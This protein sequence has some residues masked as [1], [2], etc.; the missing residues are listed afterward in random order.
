MV[1][2]TKP[3]ASA[4]DF[5]HRRAE[6]IIPM[7]WLLTAGLA[8]PLLLKPALSERPIGLTTILSSFAFLPSYLGPNT[9]QT[10]V[11]PVG[12]TLVYEAFF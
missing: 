11:I 8:I 1:C 5:L 7:Y 12:W 3:G 6:R 10:T 4:T 2:T 9:L